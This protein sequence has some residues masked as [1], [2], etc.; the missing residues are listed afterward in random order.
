MKL[1][2]TTNFD[3]GKLANNTNGIINKYLDEY[4]VDSAKG[5]KEAIDGV[6]T[7]QLEDSTEQ[8]RSQRSQ[9]IR[10]PLKASGELYRSI[11]NKGN[12]LEMLDYGILHHVGFKTASN[13]MIPNKNVPARPFFTTT[14]KNQVKIDMEFMKNIKKALKK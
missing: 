7:P 12:T 3:F 5:T 11:K 6:L 9:P 8:I 4:A 2:I 1:K 10:P 13:S 14:A